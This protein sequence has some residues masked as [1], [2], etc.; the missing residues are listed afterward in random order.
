MKKVFVMEVTTRNITGSKTIP[1]MKEHI[2]I[3]CQE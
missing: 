1:R 3:C 2:C